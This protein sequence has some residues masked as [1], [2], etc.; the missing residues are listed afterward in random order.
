MEKEKKTEKLARIGVSAG[1]ALVGFSIGGPVGAV[2]GSALTPTIQ[3]ANSIIKDYRERQRNRLTKIVDD[4]FSDSGLSEEDILSKLEVCPQLV[5]DLVRMI[6]QIEGTNPELDPVFSM[7]ISKA[8]T[9]DDKD[10][11]RAVVLCDAI[12]GMNFVQVELLSLLHDAGGVLSAEDMA[13]KTGVSEVELR[14]AVR[15]LELRGMIID[16]GAEPTIWRLRELG[17]GITTMYNEVKGDAKDE[18]L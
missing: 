2:V 10:N 9:N 12:K 17:L 15:D 6:R 16:N 5:D 14:N 13:L 11:R 1:S 8:I 4:A 7:I 3:M 18:I